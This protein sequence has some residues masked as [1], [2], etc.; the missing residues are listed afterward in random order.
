MPHLECRLSAE[1]TWTG[2]RVD[3][4]V[5]GVFILGARFLDLARIRDWT[6]AQVG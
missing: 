4:G 1:N 3:H 5:D 2:H 6:Q